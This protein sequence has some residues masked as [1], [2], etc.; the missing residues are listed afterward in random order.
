MMLLSKNYINENAP[1]EFHIKNSFI[2][3]FI[4]NICH[5]N[6]S[7]FNKVIVVKKVILFLID[8][9]KIDEIYDSRNSN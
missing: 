5:L 1:S 8:S 2:T 7:E 9:L 3:E 4:I 6:N